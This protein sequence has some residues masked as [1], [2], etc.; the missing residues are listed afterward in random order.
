MHVRTSIC[1]QPD[2]YSWVLLVW[3]CSRLGTRYQLTA[4]LIQTKLRNRL[5]NDKVSQL[6]RVY[7]H[8][9]REETEKRSQGDANLYLDPEMENI[10]FLDNEDEIEN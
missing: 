4:G 10:V 6:I 5:K 7:R 1:R 3:T 9:S 2:L 8:L